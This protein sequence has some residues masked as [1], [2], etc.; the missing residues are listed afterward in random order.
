MEQPAQLL[1]PARVVPMPPSMSLEEYFELEARNPDGPRYEYYNGE[2]VAM[3]GAS[4]AHN[5]ITGNVHA[6]LHNRL[7]SSSC[8]VSTADQRIHIPA[9]LA[10]V[11]AD[12]VAACG[13]WLYQPNSRPAAL[14]NPVLIVEVLSD[15]TEARDRGHKF[16][17][18]LT[19]PSLRHYLLLD[20]DRVAADLYTR[21]SEE[22]VW[23]VRFFNSL[24]D[25]LPLPALSAELPLAEA[26]DAVRFGEGT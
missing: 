19:I 7:R 13:E 6:F 5:F 10:Y 18:Y 3:A 15:T 12:V 26:Y 8:R 16:Q 14:L 2:V 22:D 20:A 21:D 23:K 24:P 4:P 11:Y 1:P 17:L 25:V 9:K